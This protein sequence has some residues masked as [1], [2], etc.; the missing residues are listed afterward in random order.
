MFVEKV[1]TH[2]SFFFFQRELEYLLYLGYTVSDNW[3]EAE[4][5]WITY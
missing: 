2:L 5:A 3:K 4:T 1:G